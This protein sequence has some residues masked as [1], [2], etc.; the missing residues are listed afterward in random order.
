MKPVRRGCFIYVR[1]T[2]YEETFFQ[3]IVRNERIKRTHV[4]IKRNRVN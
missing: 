3:R 2:S 1:G 4:S